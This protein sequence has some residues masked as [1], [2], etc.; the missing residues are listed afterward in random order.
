MNL[1]EEEEP[2]KIAYKQMVRS[3]TISLIPETLYLFLE[4]KAII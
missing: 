1:K 2:L 4:N 3:L